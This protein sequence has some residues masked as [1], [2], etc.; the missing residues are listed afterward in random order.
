MKARVDR[1]DEVSRDDL[2]ASLKAHHEDTKKSG[3]AEK[4]AGF[5]PPKGVQ[6]AAARGLELRR[7]YGR[8][9]TEVGIAR[10]RD[11][12]NGKSVSLETIGRMVSFFA[13]HGGQNAGDPP[14]AG[15]DPDNGY[16]A[17]LL[18]GGD[19]GQRW[20]NKVWRQNKKVEK[21]AY[22]VVLKAEG[23]EEERTAYGV[24]LEPETTDTQ[25]EIYSEDEIRKTAWAFLEKYQ[26]FGLMHEEIRRDI[27][28]LESYLAPVDFEVNGDQ[29]K[30]GTWMLRVR[31]LDDQTWEDIKTGKLTGFSIGGYAKKER[32]TE[33]G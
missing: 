12:S 26:N 24:V 32:L 8:G 28:P 27:R 6:Q 7:E 25:G 33:D 4:E 21:T 11:L 22:T 9:G 1:G 15:E 13:R 19:A 17:W 20:A 18:W 23:E 14:A 2:P 30:K 3:E 5:T 29:I 16:I 31:V 10:A